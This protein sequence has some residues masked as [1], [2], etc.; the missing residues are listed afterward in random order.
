MIFTKYNA[1]N[2]DEQVEKLTIEF[3]IHYRACTG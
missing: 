2:S 1:A 3:S